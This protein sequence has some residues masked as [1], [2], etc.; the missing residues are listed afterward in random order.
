MPELPEVEY[1]RKQAENALVGKRV[2]K[3]ICDHDEIVFDGVKPKEVAS[4]LQGQRI[5]AAH[6][7]GKLEQSDGKTAS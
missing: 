1:G 5:E 2:A 6:R 7:R 3:V 4:H